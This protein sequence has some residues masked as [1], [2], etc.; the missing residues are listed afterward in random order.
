LPGYVTT[1]HVHQQASESAYLLV[2]A[3]RLRD[4]TLKLSH[5]AAQAVVPS[6]AVTQGVVAWLGGRVGRG[7]ALPEVEV[8]VGVVEGGTKRGSI[9]KDFTREAVFRHLIEG[10]GAEL[11]RELREM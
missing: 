3:R 11:V 4:A 8:G 9:E 7:E 1:H 2:K 6:N 10:M 5:A